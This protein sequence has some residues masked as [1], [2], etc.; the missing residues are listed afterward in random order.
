MK[1]LLLFIFLCASALEASCPDT[2]VYT[3]LAT[4][5]STANA[6]LYTST[7]LASPTSGTRLYAM[8]VNSKASAP[9]TP[10]FSGYG[11]TWT[12]IA[13]TNFNT[14][15]TPT[16][17]I[18]VF[19]A[20]AISP[21]ATLPAA[22]FSASQ[23]GCM[24]RVVQV[25]HA[26]YPVQVVI[27]NKDTTANPSITMAALGAGGTNSVL[28]FWGNNANPFG[29]TPKAGWTEDFDSGYATPTTG[30]YL[31]YRLNTTDNVPS[32]TV[33]SSS[34]GG[35]AI[36]IPAEPCPGTA[37]VFTILSTGWEATLT[38]DGTTT[39]G[40]Y[41]FGLGNNNATSTGNESVVIKLTSMGYDASGNAVT[42][43]RT[44]YGVQQV[45]MAYPNQAFADES[46]LSTITTIKMALSDFI[47]AS[48]SNIT[49]TVQAKVYSGAPLSF[50]NIAV[51]NNSAQPYPICIGHMVLEQRRPVNASTTV[52]AFVVQKYGTRGKPVACVKFQA[53]GGT[54]GHTESAT[55]TSMTRS[56]RDGLPV[57]AAALNLTTGAGFTRGEEV[58]IDF[59]AFPW[60]GDSGAVLNTT[61]NIQRIYELTP[62][63]WTI[64]DKMI[65]VVDPST[66]NDST[67]IASLSQSSADAAPVAT[68]SGALT[69]IAATNNLLYS[70]NRTDGGD[71]QCKAGNYRVG[72]YASQ[73]STSGYFTIEPH[74]STTQSGVV[75]TNF[76][77]SQS[78]YN[79]Q[80][81]YNVTFQRAANGFI[82]FAANPN[83]LI[84]EKVAFND[85]FTGW[86]SGDT[87][88]DIEFL[89]CTT[90]NTYF[91]KGGNDGH[92]RL[93]RNNTYTSPS[94]GQFVVGN[95]SCF[96]GGTGRGGGADIWN[97][98]SGSDQTNIVIAYVNWKY[99]TNTQFIL[100]AFPAKIVNTALINNVVERQSAD[101]TT[102]TEISDAD[103]QNLVVWNNTFAGQRWNHEN[104]WA[105]PHN[106]NVTNWTV[107]GNS[108]NARGDHRA[109]IRAT[110]GTIIGYWPVGYS[111][112]WD[113]NWNEAISYNGDE[114]FWG[115]FCNTPEY[116]ATGFTGT[117]PAGYVADFSHG[118]TDAGGGNYRMTSTAAAQALT[119]HDYKM[120]FDI[121]GQYRGGFDPPGAYASAA[122]RKGAGFFAP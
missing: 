76:V 75:F 103:H 121:E 71:V 107:F 55:V 93:N 50:T 85:A 34:W 23:T 111:V 1:R 26:V 14:I 27:A 41:N 104:D 59:T 108:L 80:R 18:T 68:I 12:R 29:G 39:N 32:A 115:T 31:M 43:N 30:G 40:T 94:G 116:P 86:Y 37:G 65:S 64:M 69:K 118:G 60:V 8:V 102:I 119:D 33:S 95:P 72:K 36:E 5:S 87:G 7:S 67:G 105:T 82:V 2:M 58:T 62:L 89:D 63:T 15:A 44:V 35:V 77:T 19:T 11:L 109:D 106:Y 10:T 117:F 99:L 28:T 91:S 4:L 57:Y 53:K 3:A 52:E 13:T 88:T 54:S 21:T 101:A 51:V 84:M 47:Y 70:L 79:Y 48:D 49:A 38:L 24:I 66:G 113:Y 81:Y 25:T 114:D 17:R 120:P 22:S 112:G 78:Q 83:V 97:Q 98:I 122:P 9:N 92:S 42:N 96:F 46:Q 90:A 100:Q 56:S 61:T 45:R 74:S 73:A 20:V 16:Q 6:N 110:D